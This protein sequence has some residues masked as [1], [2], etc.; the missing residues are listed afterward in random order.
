MQLIQFEFGV[1]S[2]TP[3]QLA[4]KSNWLFDPT[5]IKARHLLFQA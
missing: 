3:I 5:T 2:K 1:T 4:L